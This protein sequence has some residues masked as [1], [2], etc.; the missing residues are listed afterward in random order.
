MLTFEI[1]THPFNQVVLECAFNQLMQ[2]VRS[3]QLVDVGMREVIC[4]GL[5]ST[6]VSD[7]MH[8]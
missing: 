8:D 3:K 6:M 1:F 7:V 5:C 2:Q 4:E